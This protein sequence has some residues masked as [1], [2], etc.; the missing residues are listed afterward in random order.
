MDRFE[1][2]QSR[3]QFRPVDVATVAKAKKGK[4]QILSVRFM[5]FFI[6]EGTWPSIMQALYAKII[7]AT[8]RSFEE[9]A[10]LQATAKV[11]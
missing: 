5:G 9:D 10:A 7:E 3:P 8:E 1:Q 6:L 4:L 11:A 2:V